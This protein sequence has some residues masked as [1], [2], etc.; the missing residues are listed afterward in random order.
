MCPGTT[1]KLPA[2]LGSTSLQGSVSLTIPCI[3]RVI[4]GHGVP[5]Y[6]SELYDETGFSYPDYS[7]SDFLPGGPWC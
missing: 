1:C 7:I 3:N 5:T 6:S 4:P 2:Y